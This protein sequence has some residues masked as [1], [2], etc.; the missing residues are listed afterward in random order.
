MSSA[1]AYHLYLDAERQ[2]EIAEVERLEAELVELFAHLARHKPGPAG[3]REFAL[4]K[5]NLQQARFWA[6][7][8]ITA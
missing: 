1:P 8:G 5:T 6:I 4:A 7:E 2:A 3:A